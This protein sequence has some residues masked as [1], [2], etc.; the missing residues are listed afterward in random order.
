VISRVRARPRGDSCQDSSI[1]CSGLM[2]SFAA[3]LVIGRSYAPDLRSA[4]LAGAARHSLR[5]VRGHRAE[6]I[7]LVASRSARS[8]REGRLRALRRK[9]IEH[10]ALLL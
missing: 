4:D 9:R 2:S 8:D 5:A 6:L 7:W 1:V 3:V 10:N